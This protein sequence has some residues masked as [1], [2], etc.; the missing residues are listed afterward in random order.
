MSKDAPEERRS[1]IVLTGYSTEHT[2]L[3][4]HEHPL[5]L[6][7][8]FARL[9][10]LLPQA[11]PLS[12]TMQH[13]SA[14]MHFAADGVGATTETHRPRHRARARSIPHRHPGEGTIAIGSAPEA[15][16]ATGPLSP[17]IIAERA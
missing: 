1:R 10:Q 9:I 17:S 5:P 6:W 14:G 15:V 12:Q 16:T 3:A 13:C 11:Y 7:H 4:L 2:S 8:V